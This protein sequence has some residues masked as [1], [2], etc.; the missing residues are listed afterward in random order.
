[1]PQ[2][3]V[4]CAQD[5]LKQIVVMLSD[6]ETA[7]DRDTKSIDG[8]RIQTKPGTAGGG[9]FNERLMLGDTKTISIDLVRLSERVFSA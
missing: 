5:G 9:T 7:A 1:M 2:N 4:C 8:F 3:S 6:K